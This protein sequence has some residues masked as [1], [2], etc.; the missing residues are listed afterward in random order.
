MA[1]HKNVSFTDSHFAHAFEYA[2]AAAR[3]SATGFVASDVGKLARQLDENSLWVLSA[4]TP[5][6]V[7]VGG[8][9]GAAHTIASHTDT[10][11]TGAELET[12]TNGS[13]ADALH[14]H[15]GGSGGG[16][17]HIDIRPD[18]MRL[19]DVST[20]SDEGTA[21]NIV[22]CIDFINTSDGA[23]W[24][25]FKFPDSWLTT[26]NIRFT[27]Q[28]NCNGVDNSKNIRIN[29]Q[30]WAVNN[31]ATPNVG[32][33]N[34]SNIDNIP[35]SAGNTNILT[36]LVL[37]NGI[38]NS[39]NLGA[40]TSTIMVKMTRESTNGADTYTGTFQIIAVQVDQP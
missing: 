6:W 26:S 7:A 20:G 13:N 35:T 10:T 38:V 18:S 12:L 5:S 32:A 28:Y 3:T 24:F 1:L 21:F 9:G 31:G 30:A 39:G 14:T 17:E 36:D 19:D 15:S 8:S 16:I 2:N 23:I 27:I 4:T 37:S 33:P 40:S 34:D 11:A 29:T 25:S 22:S